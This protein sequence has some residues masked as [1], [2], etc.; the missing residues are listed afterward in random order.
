MEIVSNTDTIATG[1]RDPRITVLFE[2]WLENK[3]AR[4]VRREA[5]TLQRISSTLP[6]LYVIDVPSLRELKAD[7]IRYRFVGVD[8]ASSLGINATGMS[9]GEVLTRS[10]ADSFTSAISGL[11]K[12]PCILHSV[13]INHLPNVSEIRTER[14]MLPISERG[15]EIN[16]FCVAFSKLERSPLNLMHEKIDEHVAWPE[17]LRKFRLPGTNSHADF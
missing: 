15:D 16:G 2:L 14:L 6:L 8:V 1:L 4:F 12:D 3:Q 11:M 9:V 10:A 17:T 7:R 13:H 5:L